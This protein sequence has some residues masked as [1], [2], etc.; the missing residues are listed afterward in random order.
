MKNPTTYAQWV[1]C[2]DLAKEGT[3]DDELL[4]YIKNLKTYL[5]FVL[6]L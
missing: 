3:H 5:I 4:K 2:F 1:E 6:C